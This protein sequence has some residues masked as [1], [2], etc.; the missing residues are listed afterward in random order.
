VL[1][2]ER[3]ALV[4]FPAALVAGM[5]RSDLA[6]TRVADLA[7]AIEESPDRLEDHV[8]TA[9]GDPTARVA[10]WSP[11]Q[12]RLI[13]VEGTPI[14]PETGRQVTRIVRHGD[15]LG[16]VV[17]DPSVDPGTVDAVGATAGLA[18]HNERL[19]AE[20]KSRL[21]EVEASRERLAE[22]TL[23][24]RRRLERDLHDGAQQRLLAIGALLGRARL[25]AAPE[26]AG[27]LDE[28]VAELR[29][30]IGEL[31][32]IARGVHPSILTER[33]LGSAISALAERSPV[34]VAVSFDAHPCRPAVEAA[35]YFLV[36]EALANTVKHADAGKVSVAIRGDHERLSIEVSDD[37]VGGADPGKGTGL[38]NLADRLA[39]LGGGLGVSSGAQGGTV[40]NGWA[41][42]G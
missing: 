18:L 15:Q 8:R 5:I 3:L 21:I 13:D 20:L 42:C 6:R 22:A 1:I 2:A 32:E 19:R 4:A 26:V 16:A 38:Q 7:R 37:G 29:G 40:V 27:L 17:H 31:R 14:V 30:T 41:P 39:A 36:A 28:A 24:E 34:P 35:A 10:F 23:R 25:K 9:L 11:S 12:E 33:G